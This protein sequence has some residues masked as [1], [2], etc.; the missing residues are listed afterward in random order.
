MGKNKQDSRLQG[1]LKAVYELTQIIMMVD[2]VEMTTF[3]P[4]LFRTD[5]VQDDLIVEICN[6]LGL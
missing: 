5:Q 2:D 6:R 1:A 3:L 4:R